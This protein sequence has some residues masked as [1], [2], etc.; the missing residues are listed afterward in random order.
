LESTEPKVAAADPE[1]VEEI[2]IFLFFENS[3]K[4][5]EIF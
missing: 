5:K 2:A 3:E 1:G 4:Q